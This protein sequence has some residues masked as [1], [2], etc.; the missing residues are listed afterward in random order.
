MIDVVYYWTEDGDAER[1]KLEYAT[2][3]ADVRCYHCDCVI[4]AGNTIARLFAYDGDIY[5]LHESCAKRGCNF[6]PAGRVRPNKRLIDY[7][8]ED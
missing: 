8:K 3:D 2:A 1:C 4:T 6:K 5:V 7:L